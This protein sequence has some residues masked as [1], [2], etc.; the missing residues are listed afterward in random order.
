MTHER[1]FSFS[2][3]ADS[4]LK[5]KKQILLYEISDKKVVTQTGFID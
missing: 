2:L 4:S 3:T 1:H 5:I